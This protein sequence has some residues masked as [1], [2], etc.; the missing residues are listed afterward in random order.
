MEFQ[1]LK[2]SKIFI[3]PSYNESW[4]LVVCEAMAC[5]LPVVAY[6]LPVFEEVYKKGMILIPIGDIDKFAGAILK[7]LYDIKL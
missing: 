5:G 1:V 4:A 2:S 3:L 6:D 7:L